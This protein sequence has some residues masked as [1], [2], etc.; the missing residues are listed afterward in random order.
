MYNRLWYRRCMLHS[1]TIKFP[2][3]GH[4]NTKTQSPPAS[5]QCLHHSYNKSN[6]Q[7]NAF[8]HIASSSPITVYWI[9]GTASNL[10]LFIAIFNLENKKLSAGTKSGE[11]GGW[12]NME[13]P[14]FTTNLETMPEECMFRCIV[15]QKIPGPTSW[16]WGLTRPQATNLLI[17]AL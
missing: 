5:A 16:N 2:K 3:W 13:I 17:T 9:N 10:V 8:S 12:H 4:K 7:E 15:V 14:R 11:L 6:A 1:V